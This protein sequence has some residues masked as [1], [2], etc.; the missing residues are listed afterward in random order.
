M[1]SIE[2]RFIGPTNSRGSRYKAIAGDGGKGFTLTVEADYRLG[3]E[4]N[5]ARAAR[6]LIQKLGW[7]HDESRGDRYADWY[8]GGTSRGYVF[9][10]CV[11]YAKLEPKGKYE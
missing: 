2:T 10:C 1:Q 5:H 8:A 9:V 11:D 6:L 7:F 3:S 4:E